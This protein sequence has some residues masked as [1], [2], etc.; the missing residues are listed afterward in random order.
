MYYWPVGLNYEQQQVNGTFMD[1][2]PASGNLG[3]HFHDGID[4]QGT[5]PTRVYS[6]D[7]DPAAQGNPN[8][9]NL[10]VEVVSVN[11]SD[12]DDRSILLRRLYDRREFLYDHLSD[13]FVNPGDLIDVTTNVGITNDLNHLHF[14]DGS[15]GRELNPL[16]EAEGVHP[17]QDFATPTVVDYRLETDG[18]DIE[19]PKID[20]R[21]QVKDRI[22]V[23]VLGQD[24]I[25]GPGSSDTGVYAVFYYILD[26]LGRTVAS[27]GYTLDEWLPGANVP[28]VYSLA[29]S[30]LGTNWYQ[31]TNFLTANGFFDSRTVLD[32]RYELQ[33]DL[34]DIRGNLARTSY[35]I[36]IVN[37][38]TGVNDGMAITSG[39]SLVMENQEATFEA[40]FVDEDRTG[41]TA[42]G[43]WDWELN[44]YRKSGEAV[45]L[46]SGRTVGAPGFSHDW[47]TRWVFTVPALE[48]DDWST[49][50]GDVR[51][52]VSVSVTDSDRT[53]HFSQ[54]PVG[55][56]LPRLARC[57]ELPPGYRAWYPFDEETGTTAADV[58]GGNDGTH[59]NGPIPISATVGSG[60]RFDGI[61]D[62]VE[63]ADEGALDLGGGNF[64]IDFWIMTLQSSGI[65]VILDKRLPSHPYTGYHVFI[66]EGKIGLQLA[67]S[68]G[69]TNYI[70]SAAVADGERHHV[71]ITVNRNGLG[72][73]YR[74]GLLTD[75]F[76]PSARSLSLDNN[77]PLRFG[78]RSPSF[79]EAGSFEGILDE[80]DLFDRVLTQADVV[81]IYGAGRFGKCRCVPT[82]S[83]IVA[84]YPFDESDGTIAA[85]V[86]G[87]N[88]GAHHNGPTP[89]PGVDG[90]ALGFDGVDDYVEV[91]DAAALDFGRGDFSLDFWVTTAQSTGIRVI[92]D[93]RI[94][95]YP[96]TGYHVFLQNGNI[97][98]QLS[99][100][101]G[102]TN[103]LSSA[104][105]ADGTP[106]HIAITVDRDGSGKVYRDGE[107]TSTFNPAARSQSLDNDQ[108]LR[109]GIRSFSLPASFEGTLD[110]F[111]L[112]KRVLSQPEIRG[113]YNL[114]RCSK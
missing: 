76:D 108:P 10:L 4:I 112:Y 94:G 70:S 15:N 65:G 105:V 16:R 75:V 17:F 95:T 77:V 42:L 66:L 39:P 28:F 34:F 27:N 50:E 97:G 31:P 40:V 92:L 103:Y 8:L 111:E 44:A 84:W 113:R 32:G 69:Y 93:K 58:V 5:Y 87:G 110:E 63:V 78:A 35:E 38:T 64:S 74:D 12:P 3:V 85:D 51:A 82:P 56:R 67:D 90:L 14:N 41:T 80:F 62:Y 36:D 20:G 45:L 81:S 9:R 52:Q 89:V 24:A 61:D 71:A 26:S 49:F 25:S 22:D 72:R 88:H 99:D 79:V 29:L 53:P 91:P 18:T 43:P 23:L 102:W 106:H 6:I 107:L 1:F 109:F 47:L 54:R 59:V 100:T 114:N 11:T 73:F 21:Y 96:Y 48:G 37:L 19:L 60:L 7:G 46:Q 13:D 83:E 55:I 98:I 101:A 33:I 57:T 104:F 30:R 2:R 86:V 68:S